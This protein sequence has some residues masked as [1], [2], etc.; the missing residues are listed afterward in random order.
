MDTT[1]IILHADETFSEATRT[2]LH[3]YINKDLHGK[4]D[5]Y[6]KKHEKPNSPVRVELTVKH[7]KEKSFDGKLV[8]TVGH[9]QYRSEREAFRDLKDLVFHLFTHVKEQMAKQ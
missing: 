6:I 4:L 7:A 3:E 2:S 8:V 9:A 5:S 1:Q